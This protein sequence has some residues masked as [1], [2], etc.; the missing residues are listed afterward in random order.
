MRV[1]RKSTCPFVCCLNAGATIAPTFLEKAAWLLGTNRH[2]SWCNAH[3]VDE[4]GHVWPYGFEQAERFLTMNY[5]GATALFQREDLV[6]AGV[7][8]PTSDEDAWEF[9]LRLAEHG[10]WGYTIQEPLIRYQRRFSNAPFQFS[11]PTRQAAWRHRLNVRCQVLQKSF[12]QRHLPHIQPFETINHEPCLTNCLFRNAGVRRVLIVMPWLRIGGA[13]RV[14]LNLMAYLQRKGV[15]VSV[16]ATLRSEQH[17]WRAEFENLT[18]DIFILDRFLRLP[19]F[20]RFLVYLI[21]SRGIDTVI[22]SNSY[23]GYQ[24]LPY[25]RAHCSDATYVDFVH[26]YQESWKNGGY[27]RASVGYQTQLDLNIVTGAHVK[28]WMVARGADPDRI[29]VC[30][31]NVDTDY[32][33]P[34]RERRVRVRSNLGLVDEDL[35]IVMIGRLSSEKRPHLF[36]PI[37]AALRCR[38]RSRFLVLVLGDGPERGQVDRQMR[39]QRLGDVMRTLGRVGDS[40]VVDY[41]AAAD[42]FLIPS[43]TEG[44]SVAT[45]EAMAMGV[46]PVSADVGGQGE[47]ITPDCGFLVAHGPHEVDEYADILARLAGDREL[48][49][50]MSAAARER[51]ER[52]FALRDFGPRMEQLMERARSFHQTEP[53]LAIPRDLA[54]EWATQIIEYTRQEAALDELWAERESWRSHPRPHPSLAQPPPQ[55]I[56]RRI[57]RFVW[58]QV[59]GLYRWGVAHGMDWLVPCKERLVSE[60]RRRGW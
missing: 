43:Q 55:S 18:P 8:L 10:Q 56:R 57:L 47:L 35:L 52:H 39:E 6:A 20:P 22:I 49:R 4:D 11:D 19:D 5:A 48:R 58:A 38:V 14:N 7:S 9:W 31:T 30:Y 15:E 32:W 25:L 59:A 17:P 46:V 23:L 28:R 24:L 41:L 16:V 51:I 53:R 26:S 54:R 3:A 45:M 36:V 2:I 21:R 44:V 13:E 50:R 60:V 1:V 40:E 34:D 42:V 29:E 27:P 37:I 33:R 12:P